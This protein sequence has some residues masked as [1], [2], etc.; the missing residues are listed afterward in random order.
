MQD[1]IVWERFG[2][3]C[4]Y[5]IYSKLLGVGTGTKY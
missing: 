5:L 4:V 3:D 2:L 1:H